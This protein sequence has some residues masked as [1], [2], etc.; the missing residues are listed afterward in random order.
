MQHSSDM[1]GSC[2]LQQKKHMGGSGWVGFHLFVNELMSLA[3]AMMV[4]SAMVL[5]SILGC[6]LALYVVQQLS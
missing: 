5:L 1:T 4:I 3:E 2:G 6:S